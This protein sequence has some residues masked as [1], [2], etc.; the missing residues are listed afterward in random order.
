MIRHFIL[1]DLGY[2]FIPKDISNGYLICVFNCS[3]YFS[4]TIASVELMFYFNS[5]H[6]EDEA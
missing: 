6:A 2:N 1:Q 4:V 5:V 3:A